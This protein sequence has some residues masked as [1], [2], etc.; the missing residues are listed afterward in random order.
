M[1]NKGLLSLFMLIFTVMLTGCS[2]SGSSGSIKATHWELVTLME[3]SNNTITVKPTV[4]FTSSGMVE[5]FGGCNKFSGRYKVSGSTLTT[6]DIVSTEMACDHSQVEAIF[7]Q[8]LQKTSSY[9]IEDSKL[10]LYSNG[11][12]KAILKKVIR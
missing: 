4:E 5:G 7:I 1:I 2:G 3:L 10:Y 12:L 6:S 8:S 11:V 9:E